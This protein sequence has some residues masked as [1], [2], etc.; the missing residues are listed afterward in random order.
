MRD[1][2]N[3]RD[4]VCRQ[5][6]DY[7]L[8]PI[9]A[10]GWLP[11]GTDAWDRIC[12]EI[13]SS[14]VFLLILGDRYGSIP[15]DGPMAGS[16]LSITHLEYNEARRQGLPILPFLKDLDYEAE[17]NT[18][19][20]RMRDAFRAE[21]GR[22]SG[23][24]VVARF[25]LAHDLERA[26]AHS[27]VGLLA[28]DFLKQKIS[29]RAT[30]ANSS[31]ARLEARIE[32][33]KEL[34]PRKIEVPAELAAS[35]SSRNAL[36]FAG[37]GVS[38]S[39]GMPSAAA[40]SERLLQSFFPCGENASAS[41]LSF[42]EIAGAVAKKYSRASLYQEVQRM[43]T[44]PQGVEPTPSHLLA[45]S[46]FDVIVTTN[47]D[48]LFERAIAAIGDTRFTVCEEITAPIKS[49]ALVKLH[50]S[51]Y[52]PKSLVITEHEVLSLSSGRKKLWDAVR[53]LMRKMAPVFIGTSFKDP[54]VMRLIEEAAFVQRGWCVVPKIDNVTR[55]RLAAWNIECIEAPAEDFL[56]ELR[57]GQQR[58]G[59]PN[60]AANSAVP[61]V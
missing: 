10:E 25:R 33:A 35:V 42:A 30:T 20:A 9:N 44:P 47:Y 40:L 46:L 7:N 24:M 39:A 6:R 23:G 1:L 52:D 49:G 13:K 57:D 60:A 54:S 38:L 58:E 45:L 8:E 2:A 3:E 37:A 36:L 50:G 27:V 29:G 41:N 22:W 28:N 53:G 26:A 11:S 43:L 15:A 21:V 4:A 48:D 34:G 12:E 5:L 31:A 56:R 55:A 32:G 14:H 18:D 19:D 17:R 61:A 59:Q 16:G 51:I